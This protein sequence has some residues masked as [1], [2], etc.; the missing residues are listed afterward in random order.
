VLISVL[1]RMNSG[2]TVRRFDFAKSSYLYPDLF[3][4]KIR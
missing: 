4:K 2:R 3:K 1:Q